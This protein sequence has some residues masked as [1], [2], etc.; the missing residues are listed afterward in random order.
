[1]GI[2]DAVGSPIFRFWVCSSL[3]VAIISSLQIVKIIIGSPETANYLV[4]FKLGE[5]GRIKNWHPVV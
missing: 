5:V 3:F 4:D 2:F 1:M